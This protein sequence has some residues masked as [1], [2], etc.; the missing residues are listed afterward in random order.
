MAEEWIEAIRKN[1][2][3]TVKQ[4]INYGFDPKSCNNF[5]LL[6]A[7]RNGNIN[8]TR[9]A[10]KQPGID[11][12]SHYNEPIRLSVLYNHRIVVDTLLNAMDMDE[13]KK[14][15]ET[16]RQLFWE[17]KYYNLHKMKNLLKKYKLYESDYPVLS[18]LENC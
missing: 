1:D 15:P 5:L 12:Y 16:I 3:P 2:V 6:H 7:T 18:F 8:L 17:C 11:L 9:L 4:M 14:D 10:V 13:L